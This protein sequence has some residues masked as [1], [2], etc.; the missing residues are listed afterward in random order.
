MIRGLSA[1]ALVLVFGSLS[2]QAQTYQHGPGHV[3]PDSGKH[4]PH[5][6]GHVAPDSATHAAMHARLL[7]SWHGT[8]Q[9]LSGSSTELAM[10]FALDRSR[11]LSL[12]VVGAPATDFGTSKNVSL[13]GDKLS[14][15]QAVAGKPCR[16]LARLASDSLR[17]EVLN[18]TVACDGDERTF[19]LRKNT[20]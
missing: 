17:A 7:G 20:E 10:Y 6:P 14:W 13:N 12:K 11:N 3:R 5:G 18:V 8:L 2:L 15:T 4:P 9:S 19:F 1:T 16:A